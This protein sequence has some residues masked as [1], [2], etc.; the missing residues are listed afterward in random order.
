[1][2]GLNGLKKNIF[3]KA[4]SLVMCVAV[5]CT[6]RM[7]P[8]SAALPETKVTLN[9]SNDAGDTCY[10]DSNYCYTSGNARYTNVDTFMGN[11]YIEYYRLDYTNP[12]RKAFMYAERTDTDTH[13]FFT[14]NLNRPGV[15]RY[16]NKIYNHI[17]INA[18]IMSTLPG[19]DAQ[20]FLIRTTAD[21]SGKEICLSTLG[22]D[23]RFTYSDGTTSDVLV[24][25]GQWAN[26]KVAINLEKHTADIY[27]DGAKIKANL[28]VPAEFTQIKQVRFRLMEGAIGNMYLD[29]FQITGLIKPFVDGVETP[30]D[31]YPDEDVIKNF[32][33]G[34][35]AFHGYSGLVYKDGIKR[36]MAYEPIF[37]TDPM[38]LFVSS[39]EIKSAFG[40]SD[41]SAG[42]DG[43]VTADGNSK[44]L[45]ISPVTR[46][47]VSYIPV[48]AFCEELLG[49][50]VYSFETGYFIAGDVNE[51]LDSSGWKYQS[52]RSDSNQFTMWNDIDFLNAFLQ[53]ERP[54]ANRLKSDFES[55]NGYSHPR[56]LVTKSD[57]DRLRNAYNNDKQYRQVAL[58]YI[59][60][61]TAYLSKNPCEYVFDDDMRMLN[62]ARE[63]YN[64]FFRLGF[65]WQLTGDK[66]YAERAYKEICALAA[67]PDYNTS[68]I[69]DAGEYAMALAIA[70]DWFYD[71]FTEEQRA[72]A[73]KVCVEQGLKPLASGM[74]GRL[75]SSSNGTNTYGSFRWRS[76]YNSIVVGGCLNAAVAGIEYDPDYCFDIIENCLRGY[77]YSLAELMPGGGWSEAPGYWNYAMQ[78]INVGLS[79]LNTAFGTDYCLSKSMG[80][81]KTLDFAIATLGA[82]GPN[83]FHDMG[84]SSSDSYGEFMYLTKLYK[85]KTAFNIRYNDVIVK[86]K[87]HSD[88]DLL[89]Y[90]PDFAESCTEEMDTVNYIRGVELFS[91]RDSFD[92]DNDEFYFS[93]H[94]GTTSGYHQHY[95][96]STFVLD[97]LGQRW[98]EDLGSDNYNLQNEMGYPEYSIYRKRSEGHNVLVINPEKFSAKVEQRTGQ[99][100]P[101]KEYKYSDTDAYVKADMS[102]VYDQ[103][104][105]METG[106]Y[107][108][109]EN[110]SVTMRSEFELINDNSEVYWFMHTKAD[111]TIEDNVA[112]LTRNGKNVK[113]E[114]DTNANV[115]EIF[116][117]DA[118][119]LPTSPQVPEQNPNSAYRKIAVKLTASDYTTLTVRIA[120]EN[121]TEEMMLTPLKD[122]YLLSDKKNDVLLYEGNCAA[123]FEGIIRGTVADEVSVGGKTEEDPAVAV[124]MNTSEDENN[125]NAYYNYAWGTVDNN[126]GWNEANGKGYLIATANVFSKLGTTKFTLRT[127]Q[128]GYVSEDFRPSANSWH[129]MTVIYNRE[130]GMSK[131]V[132][133]GNHGVYKECML[134]K[135]RSDMARIRNNLRFSMIAANKDDVMYIDDVKVYT[136]DT[137]YIPSMPM[138]NGGFVTDG[139]LLQTG[140]G[141][142]PDYIASKFPYTVRAFLDNTFTASAPGDI[143]LSGGNVIVLENSNKLYTTYEITGAKLHVPSVYSVSATDGFGSPPYVYQR[144]AISGVFGIGGKSSADEAAHMIGNSA[145]ADEDFYIQHS[146]SSTEVECDTAMFLDIYIDSTLYFK[147]V[148]FA[149]GGHAGISNSYTSSKITKGTW[150][151]MAVI[152]RAATNANEIYIDGVLVETKTAALSSNVIRFI[153]RPISSLIGGNNKT[154]LY[155]DNIVYLYGEDIVVNPISS[156]SYTVT[157][158]YITGATGKTVKEFMDSTVKVGSSFTLEVYNADGTAASSGTSIA[159]GMYVYVKE[160]GAVV[161]QYYFK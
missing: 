62:T 8:V 77:E 145:D 80:M 138:L 29:N 47:G 103:V 78:Y 160:N 31:I 58:K 43:T 161:R 40:I 68:H 89:Y 148:Y 49:K 105:A 99:F 75:T 126:G 121:N 110:Q 112:Y 116:V 14:V 35:V 34:K 122:W 130:T 98:A 85:N 1:M 74:Y 90:D 84:S 19:C 88:S 13:C 140:E 38:E 127:D 27:F 51:V 61:A 141:I 144:A 16:P 120:P 153:A 135:T 134:G 111:V 24:K 32:L 158:A 18:D 123:D 119:P 151:N 36:K 81:E 4:V 56:V 117:M 45:S 139:N 86:N 143:Q 64:R 136:S 106:Y 96:C 53:Y 55:V 131:T 118:K 37:D 100:V 107:I 48:T 9:V 128:G 83:N 159:A 147:N 60:S 114:F 10:F 73:L 41:L 46:D 142:S 52:F 3:S 129:N 82:T 65:A 91:V 101:V 33:K 113:L 59:N 92:A 42:T 5:L 102:K 12:K 133:D 137:D 72:F 11:N 39:D 7:A 28:P 22:A 57:F 132:I 44:K 108:D 76:N 146:F 69:I 94:F 157:G 154:Q 21:S 30:T 95:D 54:D 104:N 17:L 93:T 63:A 115:S 26:Y 20:M 66:K 125:Y 79:T 152:H 109:R 23:G 150:H 87:S 97:I 155:M 50:Y 156:S 15:T 70:Y 149:T 67:F 6:V 2:K 71:A 124:T 25:R